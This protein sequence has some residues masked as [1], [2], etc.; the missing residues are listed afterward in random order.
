MLFDE[1][2]VAASIVCDAIVAYGV[3]ATAL[4]E[5]D[6]SVE[7]LQKYV[8]HPQ[9]TGDWLDVVVPR[10]V[11]RMCCCLS[12]VGDIAVTHSLLNT[13]VATCKKSATLCTVLVTR[14][15]GCS[16]DSSLHCLWRSTARSCGRGVR[17]MTTRRTIMLTV[18]TWVR[19][20]FG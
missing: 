5:S 16:W 2:P 18:L 15:C 20:A 6:V 4:P 17:K 13:F 9:S 3:M 12:H 7:I 19:R 14:R 1:R 11:V 8:H 10:D